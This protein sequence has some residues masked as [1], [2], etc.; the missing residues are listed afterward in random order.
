VGGAIRGKG[1]NHEGHQG[2]RKNS[3]LLVLAISLCYMALKL[4][5]LARRSHAIMGPRGI[6]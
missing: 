4:G 6:I 5:L 1:F 2:T 3:Q